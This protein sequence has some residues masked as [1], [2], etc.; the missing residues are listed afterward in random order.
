MKLNTDT[1]IPY[2]AFPFFFSFIYFFLYLCEKDRDIEVTRQ[3]MPL[4]RVEDG[5]LRQQHTFTVRVAGGRAD[6]LLYRVIGSRFSARGT[7]IETTPEKG[8]N[9]GD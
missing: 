2:R 9:E 5:R 6:A 1:V 4:S 3:T 8:H 7:V